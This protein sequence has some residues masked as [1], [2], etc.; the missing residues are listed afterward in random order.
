MYIKPFLRGERQ[1]GQEGRGNGG[2]LE[3]KNR[4]EKRTPWAIKH[5]DMS[6]HMRK[7]QRLY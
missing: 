7:L 1:V 3:E 2:G 5:S 6:D 4:L